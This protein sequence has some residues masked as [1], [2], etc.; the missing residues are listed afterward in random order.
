MIVL[1]CYLIVT[2]GTYQHK[3]IDNDCDAT[4]FRSHDYARISLSC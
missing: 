4:G 3:R 2:I 1:N